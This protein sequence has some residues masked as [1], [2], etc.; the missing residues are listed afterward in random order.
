MA[1]WTNPGIEETLEIELGERAL[2]WLHD[3][4]P[5]EWEPEAFSSIPLISDDKAE[6]LFDKM[7]GAMT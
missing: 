3:V 2:S 1:A 6:D 4:N 7:I 5:F